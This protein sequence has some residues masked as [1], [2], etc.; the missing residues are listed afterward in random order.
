MSIWLA[1][2][3]VL[4]GGLVPCCL[5]CLR[6]DVISALAA[7]NVAA[8]VTGLLLVT[9]TMAFNRQPFTDLAVVLI[10]LSA[11]GSLAFVRFLG[12]QR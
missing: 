11:G 1:A 5:G 2:S 12:R 6:A 9:M 3:I 10:P 7:Y 4:A 8:V